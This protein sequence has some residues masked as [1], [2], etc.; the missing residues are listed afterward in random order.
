MIVIDASV[1]ISFL[2][3]DHPRAIEALNILDTEEELVI[4][5]LTLAECAVGPARNGLEGEFRSAITRLGLN[6]WTPD[7]EHPYRLAG[8]RSKTRLKMPDCCVLEC[9]RA[10]GAELATFDAQLARIAKDLKVQL[11]T[12]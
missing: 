8:L 9:A 12:N 10:L 2:E 6:V 7:A 11:A 5:P 3:T 4:H 1:L